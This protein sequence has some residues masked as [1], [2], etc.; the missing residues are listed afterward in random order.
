VYCHTF[1]QIKNT[2]FNNFFTVGDKHRSLQYE[3]FK[4]NYGRNT[5]KFN[6]IGAISGARRYRL[7]GC[8]SQYLSFVT[9]HICGLIWISQPAK[10]K[11][12][13]IAQESLKICIRKSELI[14]F[15]IVATFFLNADPAGYGEPLGNS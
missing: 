11:L 8:G 10:I 5:E 3:I 1:S 6:P 7:K 4:I 13:S 14:F 2:K 12:T 9:I 15:S